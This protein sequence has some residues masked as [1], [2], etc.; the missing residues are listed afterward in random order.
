MDHQLRT[1]VSFFVFVVVRTVGFRLSSFEG[2]AG[3]HLG[4][5]KKDARPCACGS[6][7]G[8]GNG[9]PAPRGN[10]RFSRV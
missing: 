4:V 10:R 7:V 9:Q 2:H 3:R 1:H 5:E 6:F 8:F